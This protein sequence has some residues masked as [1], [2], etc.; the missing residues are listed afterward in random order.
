MQSTSRLKILA[1]TCL[2]LTSS[3]LYSE[4]SAAANACGWYI[5]LHCGKSA[6][7]AKAKF[8]DLGG[9]Y[10]GG[11]AGL[12]VINT[13]SYTNLRKGLLCT[14]DGPYDT[15]ALASAVSWKEAVADA[16]VKKG[17]R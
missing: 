6:A 7:A 15:S 9:Q 10:A 11:G 3:A 2:T 1:F 17:C 13:N 12:K 8:T 4:Q 5:M 14:V 16:Y